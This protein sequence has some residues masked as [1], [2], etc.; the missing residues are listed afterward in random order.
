MEKTFFII[1][2]LVPKVFPFPCVWMQY[3]LSACRRLNFQKDMHVVRVFDNGFPLLDKFV[4]SH[5]W[6]FTRIKK[7]KHIKLCLLLW[8]G[9]F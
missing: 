9:F 7:K 2:L 1:F 8:L 4:I 3:D 5:I 6:S